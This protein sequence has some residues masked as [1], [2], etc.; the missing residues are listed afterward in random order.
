MWIPERIS[1][2]RHAPSA[3]TVGVRP[4][5]CQQ[6]RRRSQQNDQGTGGTSRSFSLV[7]LQQSTQPLLALDFARNLT[8]FIS[9][10]DQF[11]FQSLVVSLAV[12]VLKRTAPGS[13]VLGVLTCGWAW[14]Y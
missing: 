12:V 13:G 2:D 5:I 3:K 11:I 9:G 10:L 1:A 7:V 8:D 4:R 6:R 14:L